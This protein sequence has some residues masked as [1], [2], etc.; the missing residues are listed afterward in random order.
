MDVSVMQYVKLLDSI[1]TTIVNVSNDLK[2]NLPIE[3]CENIEQLTGHFNKLKS[4]LIK[5]VECGKMA[6][7]VVAPDKL[8]GEHKALVDS[9]ENFL[10]GTRQLVESISLQSMNVNVELYHKGLAN[11]NAGVARTLE[12]VEKIVQKI[13][14]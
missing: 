12:T 11:Q 1:G 3:K 2:E 7:A 8:K 10:E 9:F 5:F 6:S 14:K 4:A 13:S